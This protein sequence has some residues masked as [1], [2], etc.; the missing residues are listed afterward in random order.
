MHLKAL[1]ATL[2]AVF[3]VVSLSTAH[4]KAL[5]QTTSNIKQTTTVKEASA[6]VPQPTQ[7]TVMSGDTLSSIASSNSTTYVRLFDANSG[8]ANPDI[9]NPGEVVVVPTAD[10]QLPDRF[11]Q[12]EASLSAASSSETAAPQAV[13][14]P[15][16]SQ[17]SSASTAPSAP[18]P[19]STPAPAAV[20]AAPAAT[21]D[22]VWTRIAAC[23]SGGNWSIDTGNGFYGGL[24]FTLSS[25]EAMGG[26]GLP[27]Q[28]SEA[29]QI[30]MAIKLQA[31][32]GWGAW[33]V[34][35]VKA[36]V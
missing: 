30:A 15:A 16:V 34:C 6:V 26:T 21:D 33:P 11:G 22:S 31:V 18:A 27:N 19:V 1:T 14:Q 17:D 12:Y 35:S 23:E 29:T 24:Q 9:I 3:A 10:A 13:S 36:G 7:V 32:Q 4:T 5:S 25:W 8:I 2:I 28:A 20:T